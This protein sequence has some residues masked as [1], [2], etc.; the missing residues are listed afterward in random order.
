MKFAA[1][2]ESEAALT[3]SELEDFGLLPLRRVERNGTVIVESPSLTGLSEA[4]DTPEEVLASVVDTGPGPSRADDADL[5]L[6]L[7]TVLSN[8]LSVTAIESLY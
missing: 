4:E 8:R 7:I 3:D 6:R 5:V 1:G 2:C